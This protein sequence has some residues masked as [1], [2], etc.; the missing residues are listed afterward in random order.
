MLRTTPLYRDQP[1]K[2][3]E[4]GKVLPLLLPEARFSTPDVST[5]K[6]AGFIPKFLTGGPLLQSADLEI[7]RQQLGKAGSSRRSRIALTYNWLL[8]ELSFSMNK[9]S[10]AGLIFGL[11]VLGSLFFV[12]GFLAAV[13]TFG[14]GRSSSS[15]SWA[16]ANQ[17]HKGSTAVGKLAGTVGGKLLRDEVI[18]VESKLGGGALS[19][20]VNHVPPALQPFAAQAQNQLAIKSQQHIEGI[21]GTVHGSFS[22]H[23][24]GS[25][26][27]VPHPGPQSSYHPQSTVETNLPSKPQPAAF[28]PKPHPQQQY[29]QRQQQLR[30]HPYQQQQQGYQQRPPMPAQRHLQSSPQQQPIQQHQQQHHRHLVQQNPQ[31]PPQ[32]PP[33]YAQN[34]QIQ[35]PQQQGYR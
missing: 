7:S 22:P 19:K 30:S 12:I 10:L 29:Q 9:I 25:A 11:M 5:N 2:T 34:Q 16:S 20:V 17:E 26:Q 13:A 4:A 32:Q 15:T 8:E 18:K 28:A 1:E 24:F 27:N 14:T 23:T 33:Q 21:S 31:R 6:M 35:P 3:N